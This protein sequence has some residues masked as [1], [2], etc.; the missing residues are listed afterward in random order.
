MVQ[1]GSNIIEIEGDGPGGVYRKDQCGQHLQ[2][3]PRT[4]KRHTSDDPFAQQRAMS[5]LLQY[6]RDHATVEFVMRWTEYA[7]KHPKKSKKGVPVYMSWHQAFISY[8][9]PRVMAGQP[10]QEFPPD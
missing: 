7:R 6:I 10:I 4:V 1:L 5:I 8:N 2:K 9:L 3:P